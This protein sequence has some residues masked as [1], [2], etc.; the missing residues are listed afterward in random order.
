MERE[1]F[2][3]GIA[4]TAIILTM[5]LMGTH[6]LGNTDQQHTTAQGNRKSTA[7]AVRREGRQLLRREK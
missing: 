3:R 6:G 1:R 5:I 7:T 4:E 2:A